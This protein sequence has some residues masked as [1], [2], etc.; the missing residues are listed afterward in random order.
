LVGLAVLAGTLSMG[1][2]LDRLGI[3]GDDEPD[4]GPPPDAAR[5]TGPP[6][7]GP[8][9]AAPIVLFNFAPTGSLTVR[10]LAPDPPDISL[11]PAAGRESGVTLTPAGASFTGGRLEAS[12]GDSRSLGQALIASGS[13]TVEAWVSAAAGE[14]GPS[15]P[16][17]IVTYSSGVYTRA[18][19]LAQ[20]NAWFVAR[21]ATAATDENGLDQQHIVGG[22][23]FEDVPVHVALTYDGTTGLA[24]T[25][26]N[27]D[28]QG[29]P[30][31]HTAE[32]GRPA[33]LA[34]NL[35]REQLAIGDE[36]FEE[37][38]FHGIVHRVAI[39]DVALDAARIRCIYDTTRP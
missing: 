24:Q 8:S 7:A 35:D 3:G 25:Y 17:R 4:A 37:Y 28:P 36:Y 30:R 15:Y 6:D 29:I 21:L 13:L 14:T 5:D 9:C 10:D 33:A 23:F 34:W 19:T 38:A 39:Y 1:C 26:V 11:T 2:I 27:A 31:R 16:D 22:T 20:Q 32:D 18:F 12:P